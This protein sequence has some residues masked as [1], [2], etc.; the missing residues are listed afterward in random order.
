MCVC[1]I[2]CFGFF[3]LSLSLVIKDGQHKQQFEIQDE[4][5]GVVQ[6]GRRRRGCLHFDYSIRFGYTVAVS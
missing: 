6:L 1:A 4:A 3:P 2:A 5:N